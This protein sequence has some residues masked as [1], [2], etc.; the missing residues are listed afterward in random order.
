MYDVDSA[1]N[2][3]FAARITQSFGETKEAALRRVLEPVGLGDKLPTVRERLKDGQLP[4]NLIFWRLLAQAVG[5]TMDE[6]YAAE[7][8]AAG[9]RLEGTP[10]NAPAGT[11]RVVDLRPQERE[12]LVAEVVARLRA[13]EATRARIAPFQPEPAPIAALSAGLRAKFDPRGILN[14]G[15][16]AS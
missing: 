2:E 10:P 15:L 12:K 1:W 7:F 16:M 11:L 6:L 4:A 14:P 8:V 5:L 13:S 3:K 9:V